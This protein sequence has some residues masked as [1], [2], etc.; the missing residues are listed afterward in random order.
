MTP[1]HNFSTPPSLVN[2][3]AYLS[4]EWAYTPVGFVSDGG[5]SAGTRSVQMAKQTVAALKM[6]PFTEAVAIPFFAKF[7]DATTGVFAPDETQ[8]AAAATLLNELLRWTSAL[9]ALRSA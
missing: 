1:E 3:L 5:V 6:V 8:R 4:Q 2:A 9:A 7:L